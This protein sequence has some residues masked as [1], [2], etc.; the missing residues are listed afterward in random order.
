MGPINSL[1]FRDATHLLAKRENWA[2]KEA[3]VV[4]VFC[5]VGV[6]ALSLIGLRSYRWIEAHREARAIQKAAERSSVY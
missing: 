1:K 3:G 4:V 2:K 5:I 6:V